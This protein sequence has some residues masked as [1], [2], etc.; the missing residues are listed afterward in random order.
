MG[1]TQLRAQILALALSATGVAATA[2]LGLAGWSAAVAAPGAAELHGLPLPRGSRAADGRHIS[3]QGFRATVDHFA[4]VL[5]ARGVPVTAAGP[6]RV[7]GVDVM[8]FVRDDPASTW[9]A[10]H[11]WRTGGVTWITVV[12]RPAPSPPTAASAPG[13]GPPS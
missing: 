5:R 1:R 2:P 6:Y 13:S 4:K 8:R 7:R 12:P 9:L 11:V 10:I 3:G